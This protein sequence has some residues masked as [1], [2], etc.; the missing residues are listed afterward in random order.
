MSLT[1]LIFNFLSLAFFVAGFVYLIRRKKREDES[2]AGGARIILFGMFVLLIGL[3]VNF[4]TDLRASYK[5]LVLP[6]DSMTLL[7]QIMQLGIMPLVAIC[8]LVA[9][10]VFKDNLQ[11]N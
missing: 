7:T 4:L 2:A 3:I 6:A 11:R 9:V 10:T 8:L 1:T 5:I